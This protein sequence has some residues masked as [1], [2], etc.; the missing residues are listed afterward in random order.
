MTASR[1][2]SEP[3]CRLY[4]IALALLVL[5]TGCQD[6]PQSGSS[7]GES[8]SSGESAANSGEPIPDLVPPEPFVLPEGCGDGVPVSGQYDCH[9]PVSL[10]Y[11]KEAMG[12]KQDPLSFIAWDLDGDGRDEL[13]ARAPGFSPTPSL[14]APLRWNGESFD[15]G[16]PAGGVVNPLKWTTR[17]DLD[18]DGQSDLV[19]FANSSMSYH[20]VT[21]SFEIEDERDPAYFDIPI[22]GQVGPID[23]DSDGQLEALAVR[24]PFSDE[25]PFPPMDLWLHEN[26]AGVWTPVGQALELPGCNWPSEFAWADFDG[27]GHEDV[28]VLNHPSACDPFPLEYDPS[29]HTVSIFFKEPMTQT[30]VPGPVIPAGDITSGELLMLE[31]FDAD[32]DLDFLVGLGAWQ[33]QQTTGAALI[34]GHS[35]G[36][37]DEGVPIELPE[38]PEWRPRG[39]ADLDGDGDLD[40]IIEGDVVVDD[41]FAADPE[42]VH[43]HS[44]VVGKDGSPWFSPYAFGDFNGDGVSDYVAGWRVNEDVFRRIAMIS[45]P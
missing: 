37:F 12:A 8:S 32:G 20:L 4:A 31:D 22:W 3:E 39:R 11:L 33:H 6:P 18:G 16:R 21:P 38:I 13:L 34:R 29:W 27:D 44:D 7:Q 28:A 10:E 30:L 15:V 24:Y 14:L 36:S 45:A 23:I 41:I 42:I 43:V 25:D 5:G 26:A 40:W 2:A 17:F 1:R 19:K 9:Y 35:G